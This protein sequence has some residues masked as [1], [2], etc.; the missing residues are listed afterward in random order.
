MTNT[1]KTAMLLGLMSALLMGIGQMLGG[2]Q[3]LIAGF[4]FA[5]VTNFGSYWFSDK[6]VL[7]MY[8]AQ[9]VGPGH[10]L[11]DTVD[12][13]PKPPGLPPPQARRPAAAAL[14]RD[15]ANVT[16][17]VRHWTQSGTRRRCRD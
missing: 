1:I 12:R 9:E 7:R 4:M 3:G 15:S 10:K 6:I 17:C 14:L 5:V 11:Y 2:G 13:L 8:N 16:Q